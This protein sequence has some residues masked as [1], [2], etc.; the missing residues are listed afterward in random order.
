MRKVVLLTT[1][2]TIASKPNEKGMLVAG[3]LTGEELARLCNLPTD[4]EVQ[5]ESVFQLPSMHIGFDRLCTLKEKIEQVFTDESVSG[6]VV[7]HGTD[8]MEE[9][10]YFLDLT[11]DDARPVVLTGS[12]RSLSDASND[13][14]SNIRHAIYTACSEDMNDAGVVV[15]FNERIF[16]A[17]YVKKVHSSNVQGFFSFGFGYLGIIDNDDVVVYQK[18]ISRETFKL[19]KDIPMVDIIKSYTDADSKFLYAAI[20][21]GSKGIVLE[22]AGRGQ[23][24]PKMMEGIEEALGKGIHIVITTS[25]EEGQ[26]HTTYDYIGSTYD[27]YAKGVVLG[28]DFDSKKARIRLAVLL[29]SGAENIR[30]V[31]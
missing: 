15:V 1:G 7:T 31:F 23:V 14:Y 16:S 6:V 21:S 3:E 11:I 18:P 12:Q 2:G 29:A 9:T 13:V 24:A 20:Q 30:D 4:I 27:L 25:A 19:T 10:A 26:V 8:S 17:R 28:K 5:V 22:G